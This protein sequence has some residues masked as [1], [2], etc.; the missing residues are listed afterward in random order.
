[1]TAKPNIILIHGH[2]LGRWL[3]C[4]DMPSVP[5]P[6]L[7]AFAQQSIVFDQAFAA[8]PLC[9]PARSA[10]FS[11]LM[12]HQNGLMGLTHDGWTYNDGVTTMPELLS[13]LGYRTALIGLQ[14]EDLDARALGFGE[15]HG[16]G[17]LPR[18]LEVANRAEWWLE[19][20]AGEGPFFATIGMW[21]GHRPWPHED[22]E[23]ADPQ[24]VDV[25]SYLPDNDDTR[26]DIADFHGAIR[27]LDQAVGIILDAISAQGL[28]DSTMVIF[29]TD[30]GAAFPRAKST[31]YDSGVGVALIVRPP[32]QWGAV[33]RRE[34]AMVSHLDLLPTVVELAG[35]EPPAGL[36]GRSILHAITGQSPLDADRELVFEKTYHDRYDP[37]RALRTRTAKY[38][39]NFVE[40][41]RL[42]LP[43][44]LEESGTRRGMGDAPMEVRPTEE[45]YLLDVDRDEL[46]DRAADPEY[47]ELKEQLSQSLLG[48]LRRT[49]DPVLQGPI[50]S[51]QVT[52]R[53]VVEAAVGDR[54]TE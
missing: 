26:Q 38:V 5:S 32:G 46:D 36:E 40:G 23:P 37:I 18:A 29:T 11:G 4:Y 25:P 47:R 1:M 16:L 42:P 7:K 34:D 49:D 10:L 45:L 51:P 54:R 27:Q 15:V 9:T 22:Y 43:L 21:E 48:H 3:S 17:F 2:D 52:R 28:D 20:T 12:P 14:H 33:P 24:H 31:L 39:R 44:D 13:Q 19:H 53:R 50:G 8:A 35:G 41:P 6:R 30:H